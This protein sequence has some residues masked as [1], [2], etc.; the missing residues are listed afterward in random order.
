MGKRSGGAV[1]RNRLRRRVREIFR[2][3]RQAY[4]AGL[5]IVVNVS[6]S[7]AAA[8]FSEF[9]EDYASALRRALSRLKGG[10]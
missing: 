1:T 7:A 6:R 2:R 8:S 5:R 3:Q 10:R 4:P 9:A